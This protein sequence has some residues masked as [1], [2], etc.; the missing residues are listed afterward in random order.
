MA[1]IK[2]KSAEEKMCLFLEIKELIEKKDYTLRELGEKYGVSKQ[3]L[4]QFLLRYDY[5]TEKVKDT[6]RKEIKQHVKKI[7][8]TTENETLLNYVEKLRQEKIELQSVISN[9]KHRNK[10]LVKQITEEEKYVKLNDKYKE[11]QDKYEHTFN[12]MR[13][14]KRMNKSLTQQMEDDAKYL[15]LKDSFKK[16]KDKYVLTY[17]TLGYYKKRYSRDKEMSDN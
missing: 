4:Q 10:E 1:F 3:A 6:V 11:L 16:L 8:E 14:Y 9:L 5:S 17:N 2:G 13:Y 15:K 12:T 7:Q